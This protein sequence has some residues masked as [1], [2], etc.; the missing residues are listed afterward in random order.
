MDIGADLRQLERLRDLGEVH[1]WDLVHRVIPDA[2]MEDVLEQTGAREQRRRKLTAK[3]ML[4]FMIAAGLF[5]EESF[6]QVYAAMIEG[7]RFEDPGFGGLEPKKG[8]CAK[9]VIA[10]G[11][12]RWSMYSGSPADRWRQAR[13]RAR[14]CS[15]FASWLS[16]EPSRMW[17][18]L[19]PTRRHSV[20]RRDREETAR[21][22]NCATCTW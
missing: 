2:V 15:G 14:S 12:N 8:G 22:P 16:T 19:P 11:R 10:W 13:R 3:T 5:T 21:F 6:E 1:W 17:R 20:V 9:P 7:L 4:L 18:T